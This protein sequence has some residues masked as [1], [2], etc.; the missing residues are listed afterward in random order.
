MYMSKILLFLILPLL[1]F[2]HGDLDE[3]ISQV[4]EEITKTPDS[5]YLY[6]KRGKLL[7]Q[8]Q[9]YIKSNKDLEN[10]QV[11]GFI[12]AE[13]TLLLAKNYYRLG[14]YHKSLIF[15]EDVLSEDKS[16]VLAIKLK[17]QAYMKL[18]DFQI[19]A[20]TF[21]KVIAYSVETFP[22][23]YID[24]SIAWESLNTDSSTNKAIAILKK[25]ID[26]LGQ[27]ISLYDKLIELSIRQ[28]KYQLA[29]ET[30]LYVLDFI[31]RKERA[32]LKLSEL[33]LLNENKSKA[34]E[35]LIMAK[36]HFYKLPV[37]IQNTSFMKELLTAIKTKEF[38]LQPN[39]S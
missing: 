32:Y 18:G 27:V 24:A 23:N 21:E 28:K 29:I 17:A 37:R 6:F 5:A 13:Q 1:G 26:A 8:H 11:L 39:K 9:E 2:A 10:A 38:L 20:E 34:L 7:F 22:E 4:S 12:N 16:K 14:D 33:Y 25:G 36:Q 15:I 19:S 35:N 3:R 30:Q 31:P